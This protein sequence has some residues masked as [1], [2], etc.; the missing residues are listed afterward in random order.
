MNNVSIP[1]NTSILDEKLNTIDSEQILSGLFRGGI[2][3]LIAPPDSGKSYLCLSIAYELALP[4]YPNIVGLK[5]SNSKPFKTL[6][7]S[8]ED[9][10]V[11][12]LPRVK[13]HLQSFS[14]IVKGLL[15][16]HISL[17]D[18][19]DPI[20]CASSLVGKP[21]GSRAAKSLELLIEESKHFDLVIIDT[22]RD[23]AGSAKEVEDDYV[24]RTTLE[25]LA[26]EADVAVLVVHHPTKEV[27]R[28]KEVIN[29]VS[30]SGLS[31]TLS[32]SKLHYYLDRSR[33]KGKQIQI[34]HTK[35]N[36]LSVEEQFRD[37]I[38]LSWSS[39]SLIHRADLSIDELIESK[40]RARRIR[41]NLPSL[42]AV[43]RVIE[44]EE[45][46]L[47][48]ESI[49]LAEEGGAQGPFGGGLASE[50]SILSK[51]SKK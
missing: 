15:E 48:G 38:A 39:S 2:G 50:L 35:A 29:S 6:L 19:Y 20:C 14:E 34:R 36:Y 9:G 18:R 23:A 40:Q 45:S 26:R 41:K 5:N 22:L 49:R 31:S 12:T 27:S 17:Y 25:K 46:L 30:G 1:L 43:P 3:F 24:I 13:A 10:L 33:D 11:G 32:K 37:P 4:N 51:I 16:S 8:V 47:S 28:G 21:E 7:W 42:P 44:R